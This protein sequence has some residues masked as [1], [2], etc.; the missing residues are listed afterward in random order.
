MPISG[1]RR[2]R[3]EINTYQALSKGLIIHF[4]Y[5]NVSVV[6]GELWNISHFTPENTYLV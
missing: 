5:I 6:E 3:T 2:F 4:G 1:A